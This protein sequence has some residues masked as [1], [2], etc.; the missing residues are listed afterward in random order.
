VLVLVVVALAGGGWFVFHK[1]PATI[2]DA[3]SSLLAQRRSRPIVVPDVRSLTLVDAKSAFDQAGLGWEV[4][5]PVAGYHA[6]V[7]VAQTPAAGTRLVDTGTPL[8]KL[9]LRASGEQTGTPQQRSSQAG[10]AVEVVGKV[11]TGVTTAVA[12]GAETTI[13]QSPARAR[14][15]AVRSTPKIAHA[16]NPAG[17]APKPTATLKAKPKPAPMPKPKAT[18]AKIAAPAPAPATTHVA[19]HA[20]VPALSDRP[21]AFVL[22]G[23]AHR[24][25][26]G[27]MPLPQRAELL[28]RYLRAHK[29][30][31]KQ[32]AHRWLVQHAWVTAGARFGWWHGAQALQTLIA[33]DRLAEQRWGAGY[34]NEALAASALAFVHA[35]E[36]KP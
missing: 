36:V 22:A 33:A 20:T 31:T 32:V 16:A 7:V 13:E 4:V 1:S 21:P 27:E 6:N 18:P 9:R 8:V 2:S 23:N 28:L 29:K 25:R 11:P 3:N 24:E 30:L 14:V 15:A 10:T 5:G 19:P 34:A 12:A 17:H 35:H 26:V